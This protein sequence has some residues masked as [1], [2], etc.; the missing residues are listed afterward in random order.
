MGQNTRTGSTKVLPTRPGNSESF[1]KSRCFVFS[2]G[3]P[4]GFPIGFPMGFPRGF[5]RGYPMGNPMG[6]PM[7]YPMG[8]D[9][10][11]YA[12]GGIS[13][14]LVPP[15]RV[16]GVSHVVGSVIRHCLFDFDRIQSCF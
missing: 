14:S 15:W 12:Q 7:G 2:I 16:H 8:F 5:P 13:A 11:I 3:N 6:F 9:I 4:M 10:L 1:Q